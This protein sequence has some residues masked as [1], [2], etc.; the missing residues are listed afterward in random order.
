[1]SVHDAE[2]GD[3]YADE[4]GKLWRIVGVCHE[5]TVI[6]EEVEGTLHDPHAPAAPNA[7]QAIGVGWAQGLMPRASIQKARRSGGMGG[8]MWNGWQRIWH[9]DWRAKQPP[10]PGSEPTPTEVS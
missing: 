3:I 1:M 5:P 10:M 8:L 9:N 4:Q 6:A 2:P 7:A